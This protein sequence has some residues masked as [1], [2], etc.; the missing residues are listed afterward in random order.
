[1]VAQM[2]YCE[3]DQFIIVLKQGNACGGKGLNRCDRDTSSVMQVKDGN[4]TV[5]I[6]YLE[7]DDELTFFTFGNGA[8][9]GSTLCV[10]THCILVT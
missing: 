1:M 5:L 6:T 10:S 7:K 2:A 9:G 4:K 3:S 8:V